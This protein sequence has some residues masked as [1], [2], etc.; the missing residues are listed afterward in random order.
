MAYRNSPII[1]DEVAYENAKIARIQ[2]N[3]RK[4]GRSRWMAA[5]EDAALLSDW[6]FNE[7]E[8]AASRHPMS[9]YAGGEFLAKMRDSIEQWGGLTDNQHAAVRKCYERALARVA[10][11]AA[12]KQEKHAADCASS[13]HIGT[14]GERRLFNLTV[15]RSMSFEGMYGTTYINVCRDEANNVV[16]YKG[17][18]GWEQGSNQKVKATVKAHE[19]RDGVAQTLIQRP[20]A[21]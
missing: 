3:R 6:L 2:A 13:E 11:R 19:V 5:H 18:N 8:F 1:H 14:V 9:F 20:A 12:A 16:V 10:E 15:E 17:S 21:A 4:T 7:G